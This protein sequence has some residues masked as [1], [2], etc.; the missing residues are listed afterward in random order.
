MSIEEKIERTR[1]QVKR[2]E[3]LRQEIHQL[4]GQV[5]S[6]TRLLAA[7]GHETTGAVM[8]PIG[9]YK[10][11]EYDYSGAKLGKA[12]DFTDPAKVYF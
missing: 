1:Q 10:P 6:A 11:G 2:N 9:M 8:L 7:H 4:R 5:E 3:E 12:P